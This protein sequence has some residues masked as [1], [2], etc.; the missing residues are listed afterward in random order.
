MSIDIILGIFLFC[1]VGGCSIASII[2]RK[3]VEKR[4]ED[5]V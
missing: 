2:K 3:K 5:I 1:I 4:E